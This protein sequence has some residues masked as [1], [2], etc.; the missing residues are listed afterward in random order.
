MQALDIHQEGYLEEAFK[1]PNALSFFRSKP[2][3]G[4]P[5]VVAGLRE[6][7]F[8]H[9]L[10]SSAWFMSQQEYLYGTMWQ[11][12]MASPLRVRMHCGHPD[13]F[14]KVFMMTRGGT[15]K[16]SKVINASDTFSGYTAAL[17]G[18]ESEHIEFMQLGKGRDVDILQIEAFEAKKSGNTAMA[19]TTRDSFRMFDSMD[20]GRVLS[21][22]HSCGGV[23]LTYVLVIAAYMFTIYY[24]FGLAYSGMDE[25]V[26]NAGRSFLIGEVNALQ[27][28][29][30]LGLLSA[31]PLATMYALEKGWVVSMWRSL[32]MVLSFSP[33]FFMFEMQASRTNTCAV[34]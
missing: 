12:I 22:Y 34:Q 10:S 30:Q 15:S 8:T 11:R 1:L 14:D 32:K 7:I 13:M 3:S 16:A 20:F 31:V 29:L 24:M 18:G 6:H 28:I 26:Q 4:K 19:M 33:I 23:Y 21:F 2:T 5:I 27:W 25:A 9:S 17:R